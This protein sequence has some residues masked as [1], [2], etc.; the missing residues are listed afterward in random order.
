[1]GLNVGGSTVAI[2][3]TGPDAEAAVD[4]LIALIDG[5]FGE[6]LTRGPIE[7]ARPENQGAPPS[8][9]TAPRVPGQ[10]HVAGDEQVIEGHLA[11]RA[12]R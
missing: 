2:M 12:R 6:G 5:G 9:P 11:D 8:C 3:A 1:M 4:E 10:Q 7:E